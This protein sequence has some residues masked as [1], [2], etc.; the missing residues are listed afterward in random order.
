MIDSMVA[1][2]LV[3]LAGVFVYGL[4]SQRLQRTLLTGPMV[5]T[6]LG[7]VCGA[8]ISSQSRFDFDI[9]FLLW[10]AKLALA[11]VLFTDATHVRVR[12]LFVRLGVVSRLLAFAM[13][14]IIVFGAAAAAVLF[15]ALTFW[16]AVV[17]AAIVAPT[18][19]GLG[20]A[21]M[22]DDRVPTGVR[23]SLNVEAGLNDGLV[24]PFFTLAIGFARLDDPSHETSIIRFTL[25]QIGYGI[26]IGVLL[27]GI[28]GWLLQQASERNWVT[29]GYHQLTLIA[30]CLAS[31]VI[32]LEVGG[33]EF[34][35]PFV[36]GLFVK[37]NFEDVGQTMQDFSDAWGGL[38]NSLVFFT[39]AMV[40]VGELDQL[41]AA[42][43]VYAVI[44]LTAVRMLAV[45]ISLL[46]AGLRPASVL[47]IGWFGPRGLASIVL[48]LLLIK[49]DAV[50]PGQEVIEGAVIATVLMS[51][52]AHGLT[53]NP[54]IRIYATRVANLSDDA[55]ELEA[56]PELIDKFWDDE[57]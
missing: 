54:G 33:N 17:L 9:E 28:G 43:W 24:I 21:I 44:S 18:D 11:F 1:T 4:V 6:A 13:P 25:E 56:A 52:A 46:G 37:L 23:Q 51:I 12:G 7:L 49:K 14:L 57:W 42:S 16:E 36:A 32:A 15:D 30:L 27:G 29:Q 53:T 50:I 55:P 26:G 20:Q 38:L 45:A 5:F 39:F 35:A 22:H 3:F 31:F 2:L 48:G 47:F 34:I 19:A 41:T 8:A 10:P 40:A